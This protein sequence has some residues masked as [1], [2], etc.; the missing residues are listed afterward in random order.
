MRRVPDVEPEVIFEDQ[1]LLVVDK[2]SGMVTTSPGDELSLHRWARRYVG[3][4]MCHPTSRLD[5][6][7]S[8][9]V[10]FARTRRANGALL[11]DRQRGEY[12]RCYHALMW[13]PGLDDGGAW[14][15]AIGS[16]GRRR[17]L[18]AVC[19][20]G[21]QAHTD[22]RCVGRVPRIACT[23]LYP[24][25]GRTHQLRVHAADAGAPILGDTAYGGVRRCTLGDGAVVRVNRVMLHCV[26]VRLG[27]LGGRR[28]VSQGGTAL[29]DLWARLGG[30]GDVLAPGSGL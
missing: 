11:R 22:Y 23:W 28:F 2:P 10:V 21:A 18:R 8:G 7:V 1:D 26:G 15:G 29:R 9:V 30:D 20:D 6:E 17:D 4:G 19:E 16:H 27:H 25:T 13:D 24:G 5:R 14:S 12:R 3:S